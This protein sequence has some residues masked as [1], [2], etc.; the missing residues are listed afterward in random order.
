MADLALEAE[1]DAL[2]ADPSAPS[3]PIGER[4][5]IPALDGRCRVLPDEPLPS[6]S[7]AHAQAFRAVDNNDSSQRL[8]ALIT[9]PQIPFRLDLIVNARDLQDVSV[10]QPLQW[11][12][13][14]WPL[15]GRRETMLL[16]QRPPDD[17]L[18]PSIDAQIR[19]W[20]PSDIIENLIEPMLPLLSTLED[21]RIAHRNIRPT[22]LFRS[23]TDGPVV[24]GEFLSAPAGFNQPSVFEPI[25]RAM[26][27]PA[28]RGAGETADDLYALGVTILFLALGRNP[29]AHLDEKAVLAKRAEMG[30]YAALTSELKPPGDMGPAIRSLMHDNPADRWTLE[31]LLRW[32]NS[33]VAIQAKPMTAARADRGFEFGG[34]R[35][36]SRRDLALAFAQDWAAAREVI[37]GDDLERWVERS[38]KDRE[39]AQ[40]LADC[41][42][43]GSNGPRVISDDLLVART[44]ITLDPN[45]PLRFRNVSVMPDG[46]GTLAALAIADENMAMAFSELVSS[47]LMDFWFDKQANTS[48]LAITG[49]SDA[50]KLKSYLGK[51]GPGFSIERCAYELNKG[52]ACRSPKFRAQNVV[53]I[54]ELMEA[55]DA[56]AKRGE[57]LLDR[58]VAAFIGAR[59]SGSVDKELIEF[60]EARS[61]EEALLAQLCLFAAVQFKHGP[62]ELP[63]LA[64]MFFDHLETLLEPYHNVALRDRIRRAAERIVPTGKL[65]EFLGV[66]RNRKLMRADEKGFEAAKRRFRALEAQINAEEALLARIPSRS[67]LAGRKTAAYISGCLCVTTV[68]FITLSGLG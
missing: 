65:P 29:V 46:L 20:K 56:G 5:G 23:G 1:I 8:Y 16:L 41:R 26:C 17:P 66:V 18:M 34:D 51:S 21:H 62:R 61:G 63:T 52:M 3:E 15:T 6:L 44:L 45:G 42:H 12:S 49:R 27:S 43:S 33:G 35:Y 58:H 37:V 40:Q 10:V 48:R 24:A 32:S 13:I 54:R 22:N 67:Q 11:G 59:Y 57:Q 64:G 28:G 68:V 2:V 14:D 31:D 55:L 9:D 60:A 19:P 50:A 39:L 25:E 30:S 38:L 53:H 4:G 7:H 36:H 47:Q